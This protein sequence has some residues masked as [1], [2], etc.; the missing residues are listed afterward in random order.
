MGLCAVFRGDHGL[1]N[2]VC[3]AGAQTALSLCQVNWYLKRKPKFQQHRSC[4]FHLYLVVASTEVA[5]ASCS[6]LLGCSCTLHPASSAHLPQVE[7]PWG[8]PGWYRAQN[9]VPCSVG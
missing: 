2:S 8:A 7:A 6:L 4:L 3:R 9:E 1:L 5:G